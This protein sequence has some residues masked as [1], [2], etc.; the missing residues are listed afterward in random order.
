MNL[1]ILDIAA[2]IFIAYIVFF[3]W[4]VPVYKTIGYLL[5]IKD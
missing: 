4:M 3:E 1:S 2:I 5:D